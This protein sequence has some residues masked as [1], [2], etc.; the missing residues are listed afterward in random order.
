MLVK[1]SRFILNSI[2]G[3]NIN[4]K[5]FLGT[6]VDSKTEPLKALSTKLYASV[7][8]ERMPI[9]TCDMNDLEN[10][11]SNL[12]NEINVR[13]SLLSNHEL[14]HLKDL[15]RAKKKK[16]NDDEQELV[17][18][19]AVDYEDKQLKQLKSFNFT[20]RNTSA[21]FDKENA[22]NPNKKLLLQNIDYILDKKLILLVSEPNSSVWQLPKV[23][24]SLNDVSLRQ[25]AER[26]IRDLNEKLEVDF[27]GNAPV[28]VFKSKQDS[29]IEK[30]YFFKAQYK[31]GAQF[32]ASSKFDFV[33]IRKDELKDFI[34]NKDYLEC[35]NNF[36]LDF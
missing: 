25:T 14:R 32:L 2:F 28:G 26:A 22:Q 29:L 11:Y 31:S 20:K 15:E 6:V 33:W 12:I 10:R 8:V 19:T 35:L 24:V 21:E 3:L 7:C 36:I 23:D 27:L 17:I 5:K 9:I 13:R 18:E 34:K 1:K 16:G 30:Q 4:G